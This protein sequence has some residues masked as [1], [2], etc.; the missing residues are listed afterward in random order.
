M[1]INPT[2]IFILTNDVLNRL[3]PQFIYNHNPLKYNSS[4]TILLCIQKEYCV[5]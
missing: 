3:N 2:N 1:H 5:I 4:L